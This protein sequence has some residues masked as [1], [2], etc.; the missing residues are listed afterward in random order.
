[1]AKVSRCGCAAK[2]LLPSYDPVN[3]FFR[4]ALFPL[5]VIV[6]LVYLA[7][8]TLIPRK[9]AQD[10]V[11]LLGAASTRSRR[12]TCR[13]STFSPTR[14]EIKATLVGGDKFKVN[15]PS[16]Q[17][18]FAVEKVLQGRERHLRLEG[19]GGRRGGASC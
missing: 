8:Q 17:S 7:S 19:Q 10:K 16:D 12:G 3:R 13:R 15:Y 4:S 6:L 9:D 1:M 11:T 18:A 2:R 14:N 5:I